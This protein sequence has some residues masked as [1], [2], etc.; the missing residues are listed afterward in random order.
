MMIRVEGI[1]AMN[2]KI[3]M[4]AKVKIMPG[5]DGQLPYP[6]FAPREAQ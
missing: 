6:V 4:R 1:N 5:D 3:G 2:V